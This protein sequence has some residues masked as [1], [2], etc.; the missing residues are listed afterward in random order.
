MILAHSATS[1]TYFTYT[2]GD[3]PA[4][5]A[6]FTKYHGPTD[7]RG[8]QISARF[9]SGTRISI[10]YPYEMDSEARHTAAAKA[11]IAKC[12]PAFQIVDCNS[13]PGGGYI[14]FITR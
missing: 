3:R 5:Q 14:F 9:P 13:L 1:F 8:A 6:I 4:M 2:T 10:P 11:L 12:N 7:R